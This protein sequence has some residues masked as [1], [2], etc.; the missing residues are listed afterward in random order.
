M[1]GEPG[2]LDTE[3]IPIDMAPDDIAYQAEMFY[4]T[5]NAHFSNYYELQ[6]KY[7]D[8]AEGQARKEF[9]QYNPELKMYWDWRRDFLKRNPS[10]APYI[11]DDFEPKYATI[12]KMEEAY[13]EE[14]TFILPEWRQAL[15]YTE[16]DII[17]DVYNTDFVPPPDIIEYLTEQAQSLGMTY[18][19]LVEEVGT[20][21]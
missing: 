21:D 15:G 13:R 5:R 7:F 8:L 16:V 11:D 14:P 3:P 6:D 9:L 1:S 20:S 4:S 17:L 18:G 19:E 12:K 2:R 10:I